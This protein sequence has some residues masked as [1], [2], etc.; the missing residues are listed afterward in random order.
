MA[1][2]IDLK[3]QYVK[4]Q[5]VG[6]VRYLFEIK[7]NY[8]VRFNVNLVNYNSEP[9]IQQSKEIYASRVFTGKTITSLV[10]NG[11]SIE[12]AASFRGKTG[13]LKYNSFNKFL[14]GIG[15]NDEIEAVIRVTTSKIHYNTLQL[16]C[17]NGIIYVRG[18]GNVDP[19]ERLIL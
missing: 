13:E 15:K 2:L 12:A 7:P 16:F 9:G 19:L 17:G 5:A 8:M 1:D 4:L 3:R 10:L 11:E 18:S 14:S 6:L